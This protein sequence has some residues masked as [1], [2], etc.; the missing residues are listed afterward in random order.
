MVHLGVN[1]YYNHADKVGDEF[2]DIVNIQMVL[3]PK[4]STKNSSW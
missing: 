3:P 1:Y 4:T 2:A